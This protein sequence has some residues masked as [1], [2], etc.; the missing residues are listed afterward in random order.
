MFFNYL[1]YNG[2]ANTCTL[3]LA[4]A[5][6]ALKHVKYFVH[7]RL[8]KANTVIVNGYFTMCIVIAVTARRRYQLA[9]YVNPGGYTRFGIFKGIAYKILKYLYRFN[10]YYFQ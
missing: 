1:F 10:F 4:P 5:M 2:K 7:V 3:V 8:I 6:Q 9:F